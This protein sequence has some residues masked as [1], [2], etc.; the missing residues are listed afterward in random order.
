MFDWS[1]VMRHVGADLGGLRAQ[2]RSGM[3]A[4]IDLRWLLWGLDWDLSGQI[5]SLKGLIFGLWELI[6]DLRWL[7]LGLRK[8]SFGPERTDCK[9]ERAIIG[10]QRVNLGLRRGMY[11]RTDGWTSGNSPMFYRTSALWGRCTALT[12][13]LH[14]ITSSRAS[15]T[16]DHVRSVDD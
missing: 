2:M 12:P 10:S 5:L 4:D 9:A 1:T 16:A 13:L 6:L 8:L 11:V 7:I 14:W 15:G 3:R